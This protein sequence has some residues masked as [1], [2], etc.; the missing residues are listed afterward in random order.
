MQTGMISST[1]PVTTSSKTTTPSNTI[2]KNGFLQL[3]VAQLK[4]QDPTSSSSQDPNAMVQQL[5]SFSTLE[6]SQQTNTLLA[7]LQS[8]M[9]GLSQTQAAGL[10]GKTVEVSGSQ[11]NLSSG[12]AAMN[13]NLSSN[14]NVTLTVS[15]ANGQA[16]ALL[17]QGNLSAGTN[18]LTWNGRDANGNQLPDGSYK[19]AVSATG[20]NGSQVSNTVSYGVKVTGV[21]IQNGAVTLSAGSASYALSDILKIDA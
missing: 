12:S 8:S 17:P 21:S 6:Q 5:T 16:V 19:V 15:N 2:D 1:A 7:A 11:F 14:A 20:A 10:I 13:L 18:T 9:T 3:L 4:N